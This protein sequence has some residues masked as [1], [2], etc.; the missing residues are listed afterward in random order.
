MRRLQECEVVLCS[1]QEGSPA[2]IEVFVGKGGSMEWL[3]IDWF[4]RIAEGPTEECVDLG[5]N[6]LFDLGSH[7]IHHDR[8]TVS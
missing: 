6:P 3:A 4:H 1:V 7:R 2:G 8:L 5:P